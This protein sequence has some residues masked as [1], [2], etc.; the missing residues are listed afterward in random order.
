MNSFDAILELYNGSRII[1]VSFCN[2]LDLFYN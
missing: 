2:V 1:N